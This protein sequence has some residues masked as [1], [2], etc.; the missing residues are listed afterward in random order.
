MQ[1]PQFFA[2]RG[3]VRQSFPRLDKVLERIFITPLAERLVSLMERRLVERGFV[4]WIG[5][6]IRG[7]DE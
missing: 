7:P 2:N 3:I 6:G 4:R 1:I 5:G